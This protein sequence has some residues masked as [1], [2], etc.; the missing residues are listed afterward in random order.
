MRTRHTGTKNYDRSFKV[1]GMRMRYVT[2]NTCMSR[3]SSLTPKKRVLLSLTLPGA[4]VQPLALEPV[5]LEA[6]AADTSNV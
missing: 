6:A 2:I 1:D 4:V 5:A 3:T